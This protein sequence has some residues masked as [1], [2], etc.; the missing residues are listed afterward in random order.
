MWIFKT[1]WSTKSNSVFEQCN[2]KRLCLPEPI[3]HNDRQ[4]MHN[5]QGDII[6][7]MSS[8]NEAL[9]MLRNTLSVRTFWISLAARA[10]SLQSVLCHPTAHHS[11]T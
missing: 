3:I 8:L 1:G 11:N 4:W 2:F 9:C 6:K 7:N 10:I 5:L